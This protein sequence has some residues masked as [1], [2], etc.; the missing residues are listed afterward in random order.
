MLLEIGESGAFRIGGDFMGDAHG[1]R[2]SAGNATAGHKKI[3]RTH[4]A[5]QFRQQTRG[6]WRKHA[7]LH[8]RLPEHGIRGDEDE[9]AGKRDLEATAET[10]AT[11]RRQQWYRAF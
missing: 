4:R 2:F 3:Q 7:K 10:L 5:N 9:L 6:R 8:F 11:Y 1:C